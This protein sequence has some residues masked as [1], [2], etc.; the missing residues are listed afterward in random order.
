MRAIGQRRPTVSAKR[1]TRATYERLGRLGISHPD[2]RLELVEGEIVERTP[3]DSRHAT[4]VVLTSEALRNCLQP[5]YFLRVQLPLA[6]DE[7]SEPEPDIAVVSGTARDY[8]DSHP[9]NAV[10]VIVIADTTLD[11]D[12]YTKASLYAKAGIPE[13]WIVNLVD[14]Q[15]EMYR[16]PGSLGE[17]PGGIG[18]RMRLVASAGED[19]AAP[20]TNRTVA[21]DDLLP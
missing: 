2:E 20:G 5:G 3:Q 21:V 15:L 4:A 17:S 12:R 7:M 18:Y 16:N 13:Y 11:Y 8:R 1:W 6:L 19:V 10:L 9:T 14:R